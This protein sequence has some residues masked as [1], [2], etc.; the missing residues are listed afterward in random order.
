MM[1]VRL[2][3]IAVLVLR[4]AGVPVAA[5]A[6]CV[7]AA[8]RGEVCCMRHETEAAGD[9]IGH[10]GCQTAAEPLE[11]AAS[12]STPV[13]LTGSPVQAVLTAGVGASVL[14]AADSSPFTVDA[15]PAGPGPSP[16]RLSG[17]GFRC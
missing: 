12:V 17:A 14:P 9:V 13:P 7:A 2:L 6:P 10:C 3:L 15:S 11:Q 5:E 8:V 16:P 4:A 1:V